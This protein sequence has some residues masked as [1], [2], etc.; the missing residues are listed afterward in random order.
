M[1]IYVDIIF[2]EN[3][4]LNYIILMATSLISKCKVRYIPFLLSSSLGSLYSIVNYVL[5]LELVE[6]IL[7][8]LLL[9]IFMIQIAFTNLKL[10][11]FFKVIIMFYL[12]SLTFG[13]ASFMLLFLISPE[14]VIYENGHFIGTY[15]IKVALV[16]GIIGFIVIFIVSELQKN[17]LS[18]ADLLCELEIFYNGKNK[19]I[20]TLIDTGNLLKEPISKED[21]I[22]VEKASLKDIVE[23][24]V[25]K[26]IKNIMNGTLLGDV[27]EDV[28]KYRFKVIPFT[29]LGNENGVLIGFKPDY[30]KIHSPNEEIIKNNILIGIYDGKLSKSNLYVS[31]IGPNILKEGNVNE[32]TTIA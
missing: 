3:L 4:L 7:F 5:S 28:Y 16:G 24:N 8:K 32:Y 25:L 13:G 15:P 2:I 6:N 14:N 27:S 18:S 12:T 1:T 11:Q 9:S 19:K 20:K 26:E 10:K 29:S 21:V 22:I 31:L 17:R 23:E 30:I